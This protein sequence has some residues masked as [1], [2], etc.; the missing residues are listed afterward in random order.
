MARPATIK[1]MPVLRAGALRRALQLEQQEQPQLL[2]EFASV[3]DAQALTGISR[4]TWREMAYMGKIE[5]YKIGTGRNARLLI[6]ISE[7]RRV[8]EEGRRPRMQPTKEEA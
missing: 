1:R 4:W 7:I 3:D 5:S 2:P 6:P 8:F